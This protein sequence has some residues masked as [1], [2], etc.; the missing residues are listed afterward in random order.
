MIGPESDKNPLHSAARFS[1]DFK[2]NAHKMNFLLN[3]SR[4]KSTKQKKVCQRGEILTYVAKPLPPGIELHLMKVIIDWGEMMK[5]YRMSRQDWSAITRIW[6]NLWRSLLPQL[7]GTIHLHLIILHFFLSPSGD[8]GIGLVWH[9]LSPLD[10]PTP[11]HPL[12]GP[13]VEILFKLN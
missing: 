9:N 12:F 11:P 2:K 3:I 5:N 13:T 8:L 1:P 4:K 7:P 10:H 6:G